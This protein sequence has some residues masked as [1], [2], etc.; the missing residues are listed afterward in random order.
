MM[1]FSH[2]LLYIYIYIYIYIY[3]FFFFFFVK[4]HLLKTFDVI[5]CTG[6][7]I[8]ANNLT[9]CLY[10]FRNNSKHKCLVK[11]KVFAICLLR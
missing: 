3:F 1:L 10:I 6:Y 5:I 9:F 2:V 11:V 7:T 4:N 8:F